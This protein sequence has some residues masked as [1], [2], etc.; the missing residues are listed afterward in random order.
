MLRVVI[1][2]LIDEI[3]LHKFLKPC[4]IQNNRYHKSLRKQL[5]SGDI[6]HLFLHSEEGA[7]MWVLEAEEVLVGERAFRLGRAG[8]T[9]KFMMNSRA[10]GDRAG[11][12][13][14]LYSCPL[15]S[16]FDATTACLL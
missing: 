3:L 9:T 11:F 8:T 2:G 1:Q 5:C 15:Q 14:E 16:P 4:T 6:S 13:R 10:G 12:N 7:V